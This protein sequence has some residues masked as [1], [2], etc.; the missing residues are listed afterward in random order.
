MEKYESYFDEK[1]LSQEEKQPEYIE[2][3]EKKKASKSKQGYKIISI[4]KGL[5]HLSY[6]MNGTEYG[7]AIPYED[8]YKDKKVGDT[9]TF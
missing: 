7:T 6:L 8:K 5:I 9:I 1:E 3:V 4:R 2:P